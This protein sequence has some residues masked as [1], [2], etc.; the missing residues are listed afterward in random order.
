MY[1]KTVK[2]QFETNLL[3]IN[4]NRNVN[5]NFEEVRH[6]QCTVEPSK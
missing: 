2:N 6:L 3:K 5:I 4:A 1:T